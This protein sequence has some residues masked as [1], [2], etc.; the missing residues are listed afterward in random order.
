MQKKFITR[1]QKNTK[2][3][4]ITEKYLEDDKKENRRIIK[5]MQT[6]E[7]EKAKK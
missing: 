6:H 3:Q 5:L 1:F 4:K 7:E 2:W